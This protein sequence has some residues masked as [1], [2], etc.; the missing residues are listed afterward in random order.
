M[1]L[2]SILTVVTHFTV[3]HSKYEHVECFSRGDGDPCKMIQDDSYSPPTVSCSCYV[4]APAP[5][6][7]FDK[8]PNKKKEPWNSR[9]LGEAKDYLPAVPRNALFVN[10]EKKDLCPM[11]DDMLKKYDPIQGTLGTFIEHK[12]I[13]TT[14]DDDIQRSEFQWQYR[15]EAKRKKSKFVS[16]AAMVYAQSNDAAAGHD[17]NGG[18]KWVSAWYYIRNIVVPKLGRKFGGVLGDLRKGY[19]Y[20]VYQKTLYPDDYKQQLQA[21]NPCEENQQFAVCTY[22]FYTLY[23]PILCMYSS[24]LLFAEQRVFDIF[25]IYIFSVYTPISTTLND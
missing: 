12:S 8:I 25:S 24:N 16:T 15:K 18:G 19:Q 22:C 17:L 11:T 4:C 5:K 1:W 3:L 7:V 10:P 20:N 9:D 23:N 2:L 13:K 6:S 21:G 14:K